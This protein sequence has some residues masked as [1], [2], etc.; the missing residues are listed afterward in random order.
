MLLLPPRQREQ[1]VMFFGEWSI[2][3]LIAITI[4]YLISG[5][6]LWKMKMWSAI[7]YIVTFFSN[8]IFMMIFTS[9]LLSEA[10][11]P[12]AWITPFIIPG[13]FSAALIF[14]YRKMD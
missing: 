5:I 9:S 1:F 13:L 10:N 12:L 14:N 3:F 8:T 7:L 4:T 6:G 2:F 11:N